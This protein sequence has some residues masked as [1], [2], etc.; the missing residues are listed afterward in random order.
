M[1]VSRIIVGPIETNCYLISSLKELICIDPGGDSE[2]IIEAAKKLGGKLKYIILTHYHYDHVDAAEEVKVAL[3]GKIIIHKNE[4]D[5]LSF[6]PDEFIKE[7]DNIKYGNEE[8]AV[9][10]TP[11]HSAGSISLL[12]EKE[13]FTGDILFKDGIGRCDLPGGDEAAMQDSL[14][15]FKKIIKPG[16]M[17]YSGHGEIFKT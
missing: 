3:G 10:L 6:Q 17:V 1:K 16:M 12:G 9:L 2:R 14:E 15:K 4:E 11:G 8:L 5:Y 7:G 13:I